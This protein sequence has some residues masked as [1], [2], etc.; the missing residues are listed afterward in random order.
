MLEQITFE[1]FKPLVGQTV[2]LQARDVSFRAEVEGVTL[3]GKNPDQTRVPFSV[4]LQSHD[5][6]NH[7]QRI[8]RL[9]HP[10]LGDLDLFL[11]PVGKGERGI[12]YE[13][14]FN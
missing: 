9:S 7:G 11:V 13:I 1:S 12:R 3:L 4:E 6:T 2:E 8:Y 14:V 10:V 5:A